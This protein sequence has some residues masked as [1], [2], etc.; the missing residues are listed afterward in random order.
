MSSKNETEVLIDKKVYTINGY[1]STDYLQKVAGYVTGKISEVKHSDEY[2][3]IPLDYQNVMIQL[4]IADD[5]FKA[6]KVADTL[7]GDLESKDKEIYDLKHELVALQLKIDNQA[8]EIKELKKT[9]SDYQKSM[10]K[11]ETEEN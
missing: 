7:E 1:E 3:R 6:K 2:R 8:S 4:N 11:R 10:I 9:V 5:Y